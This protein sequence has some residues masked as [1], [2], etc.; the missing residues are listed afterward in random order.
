M[1]L[2]CGESGCRVPAELYHCATRRKRWKTAMLGGGKR[3]GRNDKQK[4][5][6]K[7]KTVALKQRNFFKRGN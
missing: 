2:L 1:V 3:N 4:A 7:F 6:G 5:K